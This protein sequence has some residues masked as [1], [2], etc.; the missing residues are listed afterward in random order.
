MVLPLV[1]PP[2]NTHHS[3]SGSDG[4]S[5]QLRGLYW[6]SPQHLVSLHP[7]PKISAACFRVLLQQPPDPV[8]DVN[9]HFRYYRITNYP[10]TQSSYD[11]LFPM[12]LCVGWAGL[13]HVVH[14][15]QGP[16]RWAPRL[17]WLMC[18]AVAA[19]CGLGTSVF[20]GGPWCSRRLP[21]AVASGP[22]L[23]KARQRL[24]RLGAEAPGLAH[25]PSRLVTGPSDPRVA[26]Y[27]RRAPG[28][29]GSQVV[30]ATWRHRGA[31]ETP[32]HQVLFFFFLIY[33]FIYGCVGSSFLCE[34]FL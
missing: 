34:G 12:F 18:R 7:L 22:Y 9:I 30:V 23:Q 8:P 3:S 26:G 5:S 17:A 6:G 29:H 21:H 28:P 1:L 25:C 20:P 19:C 33:L 27:K 11:L 13:T 31:W 15:A 4:H 32:A 2:P 16:L 14:S 24:H 10:N